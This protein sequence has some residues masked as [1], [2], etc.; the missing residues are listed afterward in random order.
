MEPLLF[1]PAVLALGLAAGSTC[2]PQTRRAVDKALRQTCALL[3]LKGS[4]RQPPGLG[5]TVVRVGQFAL[6]MPM[7]SA[8]A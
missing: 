4:C 3:G 2:T 5:A 7:P 6:T 1:D 8:A